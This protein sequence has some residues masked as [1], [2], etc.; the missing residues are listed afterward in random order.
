[1]GGTLPYLNK[2]KKNLQL[3]P[4]VGVQLSDLKGLRDNAVIY[5]AGISLLMNGMSSR[6]TIDAQ[7]RPVFAPDAGNNAVVSDRKWQFVL[8]YRID[9]N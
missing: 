2:E 6:F 8:K 3:Q 1:L 9:F 4:A 7:N 5:D